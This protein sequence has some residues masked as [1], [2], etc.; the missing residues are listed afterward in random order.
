MLEFVELPIKTLYQQKSRTVLTL[1]GIVIGIAVIIAMISIGEGLKATMNENLEKMQTTQITII[2]AGAFGG[3]M[4][5]PP[6]ET[7]P[8]GRNDVREI[9]K[10]PGVKETSSMYYVAATVE[11]K[12]EKK[13]LATFGG[14]A[15]VWDIYSDFFSMKEGRLLQDKD[16]NGINIGYLV[17]KDIFDREIHTGDTLKINDKKFKVVGVIDEMGSKSDD[18]Q[19]YM[20][21]KASQELF[22]TK[23]INYIIAIADDQ[24]VVPEVTRKIEEKLKKLRGGKDFEIMTP[25]DMAEQVFT[26]LNIVTFVLAGIASISL[27][28]GGIIIMNTML[29]SV[30]ERTREIGV[31][32]ATGASNRTVLGLFLVESGLVGF[33]G[34]AIGIVFGVGVAKVIEVIGKEFIGSMFHTQISRELVVAALLFSLIVGSVSGVY[35]AYKAAKM[36]PIEALRYE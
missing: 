2:P 29:M 20:T 30:M 6:Q 14:E 4:M 11:Y 34:G 32:K 27:F 3:G 19:I 33:L 10:I 26:I 7:V 36:D 1:M 9:D 23:D 31:M 8:F 15:N 25:E 13:I 18:E 35:P 5:G 22:D 24:G 12:N 17:A 16:Y 21:L 28:I